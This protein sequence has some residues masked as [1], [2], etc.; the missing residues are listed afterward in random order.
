MGPARS[1]TIGATL[2]SDLSVAVGLF[3]TYQG[4][5]ELKRVL[6]GFFLIPIVVITVLY[7]SFAGLSLAVFLVAIPALWEYNNVILKERDWW[8]RLAGVVLG[9]PVPLVVY[10]YGAAALVPWLLGAAA[11]LFSVRVTVKADLAAALGWVSARLL[12]IVYIAVSLAHII[13]LSRIEDGRVWIVFVLVTIWASDT[14]AFYV[15]SAL[16]KRKFFPALSPNKTLEG[17]VGGFVGAL[18]AA[19][20]MNVYLGLGPY[21]CVILMAAFIYVLSV[22]GDLVE[23]LLKRGAGVKDSGTLIPGHGGMLDRID[24]TL[25]ALPAAYYVLVFATRVQL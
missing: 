17:A 5:F 14:F 24:S 22:F 7:A 13:L 21:L 8:S 25:F 23:S 18:V 1:S 16:G 9:V 10:F 20:V 15:G 19:S 6:A 11:V 4:R 12:G 3:I 2:D